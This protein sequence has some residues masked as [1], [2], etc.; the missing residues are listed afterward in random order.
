M[1]KI[2]LAENELRA[3]YKKDWDATNVYVR[4]IGTCKDRDNKFDFE[5]PETIKTGN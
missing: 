1:N 3:K 4:H 5:L 2:A